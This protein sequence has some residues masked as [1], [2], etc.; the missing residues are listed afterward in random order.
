MRE[1]DALSP[2]VDEAARRRALMDHGTTLLVE[3][4]AGSGKTALIAGRVVMMLAGGIPPNEIV[5]IAFT[6][7]AASELLE[8]IEDYVARLARGETPIELAVAVGNG[9]SEAQVA[10][11]ELAATHL[12]QVT[13]TTIHGFCQQLIRPYPVEAG[14][15]P[16][17]EIIDPTA[18]ELAFHD[19]MEAWLSDRFG[20]GRRRDGLGRVPPMPDLGG[21]EDYFAE[22]LI[23]SPDRAVNLIV[24]TAAFL[25]TKRTATAPA[26]QLDRSVLEQL[27]AEIADFVRWYNDCGVVEDSTGEVVEDLDRIIRMID[28]ALAAPMTGRLLA[29]LLF[30]EPPNC[31]NQKEPR[32]N[33]WG[34]KTKWKKAA[35]ATGRDVTIGEQLSEA[36]QA[37]YQRCSDAYRRF[38]TELAGAA[39]RRFLAEFDALKDLYAEYK[40]QAAL[41]DFD[42]LL[43]HARDLLATNM[44]VRGA[45]SRRYPRVVVDEFQ[46]TDW[47]PACNFDPCLG[48]IGVQN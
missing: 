25:K 18:A 8:R 41:L 13:C 46:D 38:V 20:R 21:E 48:V 7:A 3:A 12:D 24:K 44:S 30:H 10:A 6:E 42:D 45:L 4:G 2:L 31:R 36:G 40:R 37:H 14:I 39:S 34:R 9:L 47:K 35:K 15:D 33:A 17:A 23:K 22:L 16:G 5:A 1:A 27:R 26:G 11:I 28:E 32:F 19:L 43:H 29:K